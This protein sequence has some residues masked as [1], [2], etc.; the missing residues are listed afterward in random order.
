MKRKEYISNDVISLVEYLSIDDFSNYNNWL[1]EDTQKGYNFRFNESFENFIK[2]PLKQRFFASIILKEND[3]VIGNI[4]ISPPN[5]IPDLAIGIYKPFRN[6]GFGTAAFM[7]GTKYAIDN[8]FLD[9]LF[10]GCYEENLSSIKMLKKCGYVPHPDGN[11]IEKHFLSNE[12]L[13][14]LDFVYKKKIDYK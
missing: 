7:L 8:L 2:Q 14:Q 11:L 6:H 12:D 3:S 4:G 1:D 10:A 9:E 13:V 5:C